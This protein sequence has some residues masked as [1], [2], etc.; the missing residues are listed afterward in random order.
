VEL[1][2]ETEQ[3]VEEELRR[4]HFHSVDEVIAEGAV[5][6]RSR[7]F[8]AAEHPTADRKTIYELL[9]QSPFAGSDLQIERQKDFPKL[10]I[11]EWATLDTNVLSGFAGPRRQISGWSE[12]PLSSEKIGELKVTRTHLRLAS[13]LKFAENPP[14][15][16]AI[17]S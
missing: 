7:P 1:K 15:A 10:L 16:H 17:E 5:P 12:L 13:V 8:D 6:H 14:G 9:T 3:L 11:C 4:G 2:P